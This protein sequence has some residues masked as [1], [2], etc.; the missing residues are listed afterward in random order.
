MKHDLHIDGIAYRLRPVT[1]CDAQFIID[2]RLEDQDRNKFINR[3]S[4][5]LESQKDWLERYFEREGDYYFVVENK[6]NGDPE[7]LVGIY[8]LENSKAEWGRWVIKKG[9]LAT[10]ECLDLLFKIAFNTLEIDELYCRTICDNVRV[11]SLHD[12]LPQLKRGVL[13]SQIELNGGNYD[14]VEHYTTPKHYSEKIERSLERK[15][16][17]IFQR[18]L[19][20]LIGKLEFHHIG[21]ATS[22][23]EE[24]FKL[25]RFLGY[26]REGTQ[27]EDHEQGIKGQFIIASGQ[28]RIELLENLKDSGT[29]DT[30]LKNRVKMYHFAYKTANIEEAINIL[31][32]NRIRIVSPLKMSSYFKKRICF[33]MLSPGFLLELIED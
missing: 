14:V 15:A 20:S 9:S 13:T 27:F 6:L 8:D 21:L 4:S 29:L 18:N 17:L 10:T 2:L 32:R 19:R 22:S 7:G 5:D 16:T 30:W 24:E 3:I 31:N 23:I 1:L 12:S 26:E 28:P 33:F 11:V 25:Y